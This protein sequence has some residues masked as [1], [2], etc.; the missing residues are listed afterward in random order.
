MVN[1]VLHVLYHNKKKVFKNPKR[2]QE[3]YG[4]MASRIG[5]DVCVLG[6]C[7]ADQLTFSEVITNPPQSDESLWGGP[8]LGPH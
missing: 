2:Q 3:G 4:P 7:I 1:F 5:L 6:R 8:G